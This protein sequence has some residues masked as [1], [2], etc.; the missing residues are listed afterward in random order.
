MDQ[1]NDGTFLVLKNYG[2]LQLKT[3]SPYDQI[4]LAK[5]FLWS[6]KYVI[7]ELCFEI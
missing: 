1:P 3:V 2:H 7:V 5:L 6:K 4:I